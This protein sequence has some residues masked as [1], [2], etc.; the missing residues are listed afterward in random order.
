M[1]FQ[2]YNTCSEQR[3]LVRYLHITELCDLQIG[4]HENGSSCILFY[5]NVWILHG[6]EQI[7][8]N[9]RQHLK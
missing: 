1:Y 6:R 9:D 7:I 5:V 3:S 2:S 8:Q 4:I